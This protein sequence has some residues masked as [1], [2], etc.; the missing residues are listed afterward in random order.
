[1]WITVKL[2]LIFTKKYL[3]SREVERTNI[4]IL[5]YFWLTRPGEKKKSAAS[6]NYRAAFLH[7]SH[8]SQWAISSSDA[9]FVT[10]KCCHLVPTG[11]GANIPHITHM[12]TLSEG[13][14]Y[15]D[16]CMQYPLVWTM[17]TLAEAGHVCTCV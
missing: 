13:G 17:D 2:Y 16:V 15:V 1:M 11:T 10:V 6:G 9:V 12:N 4:L 7:V 8:L 5:K 3:L 14:Y